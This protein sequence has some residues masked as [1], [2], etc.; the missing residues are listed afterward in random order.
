MESVSQRLH[1]KVCNTTTLCLIK[2]AAAILV[3]HIYTYADDYACI[4]NVIWYYCYCPCYAND[5]TNAAIRVPATLLNRRPYH[6]GV[7]SWSC[8]F[9]RNISSQRGGW[10]WSSLVWS[11]SVNFRR[12]TS[13]YCFY[14]YFCSTL[15]MKTLAYL[16]R[17]LP[18]CWLVGNKGRF[19]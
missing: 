15:Y 14:L 19:L 17:P 10:C 8:I 3:A 16:F 18:Y 11:R 9:H 1:Y 2:T 6:F 4:L 12:S 13:T 7:H 5:V